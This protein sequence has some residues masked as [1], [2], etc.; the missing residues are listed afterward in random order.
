[1]TIFMN[2]NTGRIIHAVEGRAV[3]IVAPFLKLLAKKASKL[4]AVAVDMSQ[5]YVKALKENLAHVDIVFDRCSC[6]PGYRR[7]PQGAAD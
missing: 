1:M 4:K 3:E 5:S 7:T 2:L 6:Q